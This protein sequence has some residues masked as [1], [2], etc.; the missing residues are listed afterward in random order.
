M[1]SR[2]PKPAPTRL[3]L[4]SGVRADRINPAEPE[5]DPGLPDP[6]A[7]LGKVARAEWARM[8]PQLH[9][10]GIL[11]RVDGQALAIYCTHYE[12]WA[13]AEA[14]VRKFGLLVPTAG[15]SVKASPYLAIA[16]AAMR[17]MMRILAEFGCTPSSRS[18]VRLPDVAEPEDEIDAFLRSAGG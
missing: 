6:P 15:G 1:G 18:R 14:Q 7:V 12:R 4:L 17:D 8:A 11:S 16:A 2:G 9:A 5:P 3:K 13:E 10:M